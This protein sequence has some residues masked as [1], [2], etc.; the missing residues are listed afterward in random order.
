MGFCGA[1]E[2]IRFLDKLPGQ[3]ADSGCAG[4]GVVVKFRLP[5]IG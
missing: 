5:T 4:S 3:E 1:R 2:V